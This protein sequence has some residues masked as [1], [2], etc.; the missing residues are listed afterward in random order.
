VDYYV[1]GNLEA[2]IT[3]VDILGGIDVAVDCALYDGNFRPPVD[4]KA[5]IQHMDG[6]TALR[7]AR[8]RYS[9]ND[10]DRSRRQQ[11]V[12]RAI[13]TKALQV[14]V[15]PKVPDIWT[16]LSRF[17]QTDLPANEILSLAYLGLQ[18]PP[19][20]IRSRVIGYKQVRDIVGYGGAMVL[21]P[22]S[23]KLEEAVAEFFDPS[24]PE[25]PSETVRVILQNG[26]ARDHLSELAADRLRW[27]GLSTTLATAG[28]EDYPRT[29]LL[30]Y[31]ENPEIEARLVGA[32]RIAQENVQHLPEAENP[33]DG[34]MVLVLGRDYSPC[35]R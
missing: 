24:P 7:Y 21:A 8:A 30:V 5:G 6:N 17:V 14:N 3:L 4:I 23:G 26:T 16:S 13:W 33:A 34:D 29:L 20:N 12:L 15:L 11:R 32:F 19:Q 28:R 18:M 35:E 25:A 1:R 2:L 10:F 22:R 27:E 31:G 9:T